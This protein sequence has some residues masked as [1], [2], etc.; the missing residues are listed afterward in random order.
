MQGTIQIGNK[1]LTFMK[2]SSLGDDDEISDTI[3][4]KTHTLGLGEEHFMTTVPRDYF[5][6]ILRQFVSAGDESFS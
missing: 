6:K 2:G 5:M 3:A 4:F 1:T